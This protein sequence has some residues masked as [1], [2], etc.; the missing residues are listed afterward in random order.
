LTHQ[1]LSRHERRF[2]L[3]LGLP[4]L[5]L[6]FAVT[7]VS[8]LLPVILQGIS[9]TALAG[10]LLALEGI[11]A[12][13]APTLLGAWSDR[14]DTRLGPR[15]PFVCFAAPVMVVALL[16]LPL[17]GSLFAAAAALVLFYIGY[18]AYFTPHFALYIDLVDEDEQGRSQGTMNFLREVGLG[19]GLVGGPA[20]MA[21]G[22]GVPFIAAAAVVAGV[23]VF[24]VLLLV[25]R[26]DVHT[27][28]REGRESSFR[29]QVK[30]T[31]EVMRDERDVR[32]TLIANA[33]WE[34]A[35]NAM[36]AFVV[37]YFT[38]GLGFSGTKTSLVLLIV[39]VAAI[40]VAP[41]SGV[42]SD[43][44]GDERVLRAATLVYAAGVWVPAFF[45]SPWVLLVIPPVAA[46]AVVV[47]TLPFSLLMSA[48]P[49][50]TGEH[51]AGGRG[52]GLFGISRGV[53]L[54]LGPL[55]GGL[56]IVACRDLLASS[57][58]YGAVFLVAA[59]A[60]AASAF[61]IRRL[62]DVGVRNG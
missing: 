24:F 51:G 34:T 52:S 1:D 35:L 19:L 2:L 12:L 55:C 41:I 62:E 44:Y 20:L 4:S 31:L 7:T 59:A 9:G 29:E 21:I 3:A 45:H 23:T 48:L 61:V 46:S 22:K 58:G 50:N 54:L 43:R 57:Q 60:I 11:F 47:M 42:L 26:R 18:F 36:R 40:I 5:P 17:S 32:L 10:A 16:L 30:R 6:A 38:V 13:F 56:A 53:G 37:L 49:E 27:P 33:L 25:R 28:Q 39:A 15:L 8:A 14:I